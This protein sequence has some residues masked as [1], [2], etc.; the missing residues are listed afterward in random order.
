MSRYFCT[1][2]D[3]RHLVYGL[4]LYRSLVRCAGQPL[5][6]FVLC[7]DNIAFD[8]L[9]NL[10]LP[11]VRLLHLSDLE[12]THP[13]LATARKN[14]SQ[15]EYYFTLTPVLPCHLLAQN[16]EIELLAYVDADL[17][18]YSAL[19][20]I[21]KELG[22]GS[23]LIVP[24]RYAGGLTYN[25]GLLLFRN[26]KAGCA[27]LNWWRERCVEWCYRRHENGKFADEGYL[28]DWPSRF[29]GV[30]VSQHKGIGFAP[31]NAAKSTLSVKDGT[32]FVDSDP[33]VFY[34]FGAVRMT[35]PYLLRHNLPYY[36]TRMTWALKKL[37]YAPYVRA[38]R[39]AAADASIKPIADVEW[40]PGNT[41]KRRLIRELFFARLI[42]AGPLLIELDYG[43]LGP[44]L[45]KLR[46]LV[47]G[48]S[49]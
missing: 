17:Y 44:M 4:A 5:T 10:G 8:S 28:E 33:L 32:V 42:A 36:R 40:Q 45:V 27:C 6:L 16:P 23:I 20:P 13:S 31:W 46:K 37:V 15:I 30:V 39:S 43:P 38:L 34:H 48:L 21:Y 19:D 24:Y 29:R 11:G 9:R 7:L 47:L 41:F 26:D 1:Y 25:V 35:R 2:L 3:N 14:R 12:H 49:A 22:S 18:F